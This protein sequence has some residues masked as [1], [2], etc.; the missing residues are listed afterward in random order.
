MTQIPIA[1][2]ATLA[3]FEAEQ[4]AAVAAI[5]NGIVDSKSQAVAGVGTWVGNLTGYNLG[6][7]QAT[8]NDRVSVVAIGH[9]IVKGN[10]AVPAYTNGFIPLV[11]RWL[12]RAF[13]DGGFGLYFL[14]RTEWVVTGSWSST[15]SYGPHG[16]TRY[17]ED[18]PVPTHEITIVADSIDII[19]IDVVGAG[20]I[21]YTIDGGA[22]QTAVVAGAGD[23]ATKKVTVSLGSLASHT[24]VFSGPASGKFYFMGIVAFKGTTGALLHDWALSGATTASVAVPSFKLD[25]LA[26]L[27]PDLVM[28]MCM[29][30]D[31]YTQ[32]PLVTFAAQLNTIIDAAQATGAEVLLLL[33]P[34]IGDV[35]AITQAEYE[36]QVKSIAVAQGVPWASYSD[37]W[38][39]YANNLARMDDTVH[40]TTGGHGD[41][42]TPL[43]R[44]LKGA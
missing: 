14:G 12:Q 44:L 16:I 5:A 25:A 4:E 40:P 11:R 18:N 9:S 31:H 1:T 2:T 33:E 34:D 35:F 32:V 21:T 42:A 7:W 22:P 28:V 13:G 30:N 38:G 43:V 41:M 29:I 17:V 36:T 19:Y 6:K 23:T 3:T 37:L 20:N 26:L 24:V 8:T 27:D 39:P 15:G 10:D